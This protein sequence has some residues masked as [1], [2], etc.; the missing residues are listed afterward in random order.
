MLTIRPSSICLVSAL[1]ISTGWICR[2]KARPKTPSTSDSIRFSMFLRMPKEPYPLTLAT[3]YCN[4]AYIIAARPRDELRDVQRTGDHVEPD[5]G[6]GNPP[7]VEREVV[8]DEDQRPDSRRERRPQR[9]H[10]RA[11]EQRQ[12]RPQPHE[13]ERH[14]EHRSQRGAPHVAVDGADAQAPD[15]A[16]SWHEHREP[17]ANAVAHE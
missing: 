4:T 2:L 7:V 13:G 15:P 8:A 16:D 14:D 1:A 6:V 12:P 17:E 10:E 9:T 3:R 5:A 11:E